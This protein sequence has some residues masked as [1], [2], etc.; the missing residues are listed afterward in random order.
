MPKVVSHH[1]VT[2]GTENTSAWV[3]HGGREE[4]QSLVQ[5]CQEPETRNQ[6]LVLHMDHHSLSYFALL[7]PLDWDKYLNDTYGMDFGR[8]FSALKEHD[9]QY[10]IVGGLAMN[11]HGIPRITG[12]LDLFV[13]LEPDNMRR[14]LDTVAAL[15][16]GPKPPID[17]DILLCSI[18][19]AELVN[20]E[21]LRVCTFMSL[22]APAMEIDIR[23]DPP[24]EFRKVYKRKKEVPFG[25]E[26]IPVLSIDDMIRWKSG[27][28]RRQDVYDIEAL[29]A[30]MKMQE[31]GS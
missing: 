2:E 28:K 20:D 13:D 18:K 1:R 6:E 25:E 23:L 26:L 5:D 3:Y 19:R 21:K 7:Q 30:V 22:S 12:H 15:D 17:Q 16:C 14:F 27:S 4:F 8:A 9:V 29:R 24:D 11:L 31:S 10:L